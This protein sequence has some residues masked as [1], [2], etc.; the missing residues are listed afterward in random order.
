L[1]FRICILNESEPMTQTY[2]ITSIFHMDW[3][4][5][6]NYIYV[7]KLLEPRQSVTW[8]TF[9]LVSGVTIPDSSWCSHLF[10]S[11][12]HDNCKIVF[13]SN[14]KYNWTLR[15]IPCWIQSKKFKFKL[16]KKAEYVSV[17]YNLHEIHRLTS[18]AFCDRHSTHNI[19]ML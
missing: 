18:D 13:K 8:T 3:I 14:V 11:L 16:K 6:I 9:Q 5:Q 7:C 12:R 19:F 4:F 1:R 17:G 2:F 15:V 10:Y